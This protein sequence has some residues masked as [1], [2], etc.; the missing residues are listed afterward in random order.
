MT[1]AEVKVTALRDF[2][3]VDLGSKT[4]G[5]RFDYD[6]DKDP[7]DLVKLGLVQLPAKSAEK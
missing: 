5:D 3:N 2:R 1:M 7:A 4:K 6:V